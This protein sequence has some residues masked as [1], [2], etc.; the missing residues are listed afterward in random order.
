MCIKACEILGVRGSV[1]GS[2]GGGVDPRPV[3]GG[4]EKDVCEEKVLN[5]YSRLRGTHGRPLT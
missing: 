4:A 5:G 3:P 1:T 2:V